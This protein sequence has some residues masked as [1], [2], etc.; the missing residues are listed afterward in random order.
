MNNLE[1]IRHK[2]T[3]RGLKP[4]QQRIAVLDA[5]IKLNSHPTAEGLHNY[6]RKTNPSISLA[7]VYNTLEVLTSNGLANLVILSRDCSRYDAVM[8]NHF[9]LYCEKTK[10]VEDF[11]DGDLE[12]LLFEYLNSKKIDGFTVE[13][14]EIQLKGTFNNNNQESH[15]NNE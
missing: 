14:V 3:E 12:Q 7:T 11:F 6:L 10:K 1:K 15:N 2:L 5:L 4:T 9:H 13:A 8:E